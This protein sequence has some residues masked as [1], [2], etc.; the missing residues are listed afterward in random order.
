MKVRNWPRLYS[1]PLTTSR[2]SISSPVPGIIGPEGDPGGGG[3]LVSISAGI[4]GGEA[5]SL[6]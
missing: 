6:L 1:Y 5:L 4:V 2:F 3:A